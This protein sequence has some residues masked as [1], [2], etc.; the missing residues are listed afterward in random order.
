VNEPLAF[1]LAENYGRDG[2]GELV[3]QPGVEVL[4][5]EVCS[6]ADPD[7]A[8]TGGHPGS[9]PSALDAVVDDVEGS[10]AGALP[11]ARSV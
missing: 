2:D 9:G 10:A 11:R 4:L 7:V 3:H 6:S 5:D 8:A 1:A